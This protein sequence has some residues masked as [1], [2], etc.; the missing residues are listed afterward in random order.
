MRAR[1]RGLP[2]GTRPSAARAR[3]RVARSPATPTAVSL[4]RRRPP[5][6]RST[7]AGTRAWSR[8]A[9]KRPARGS[10]YRC[11]S[12]SLQRSGSCDRETNHPRRSIRTREC[13]VARLA[14]G[15]NRAGPI[16]ATQERTEL[17]A[18]LAVKADALDPVEREGLVHAVD[19]PEHASRSDE[20]P[21]ATAALLCEGSELGG[22][23]R[24]PEGRGE[25]QPVEVDPED[26]ATKLSVVTSAE[27]RGKLADAGPA[28]VVSD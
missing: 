23:D 24:L 4:R 22:T 16:G 13:V 21:N 25:R 19:V 6:H 9:R 26:R 12:D 2:R 18:D 15:E 3:S 27:T 10:A 7:A 11:G 28:V 5:R 20:E 1:G 14:D 17:V 8:A